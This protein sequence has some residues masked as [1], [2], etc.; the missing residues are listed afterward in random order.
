MLSK[1]HVERLTPPDRQ[2]WAE[3]EV[4]AGHAPSIRSLVE[5]A[6]KQHRLSD[7]HYRALVDDVRHA[8]EAKGW[9]D[10]VAVLR[11]LEASLNASPEA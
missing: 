4:R 10:G 9:L 11:D 5:E 6:V 3:A 1:R 7:A 8:G 2:A